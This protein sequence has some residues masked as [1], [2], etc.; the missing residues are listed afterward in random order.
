MRRSLPALIA[1]SVL[2]LGLTLLCT[3]TAAE[4]ATG[5]L[6]LSARPECQVWIDD[7]D[8]G[9]TDKTRNGIE[10][11]AGSYKVRFICE[12]ADCEGFERRSGVKTLTVEA[13][14][15]THYVADFYFLNDRTIG[16][17]QRAPTEPTEV[18]AQLEVP[19]DDEDL[20]PEPSEPLSP[21]DTTGVLRLSARP[22][23]AVE[24]DG[25]FAGTSDRTRLGVELEPG[26]Y[27]VRFICE[28]QVCEDFERRSGVK[29]LEVT[30]G[31]TVTYV[32]DF[33]AL[34]AR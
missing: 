20:G 34:N 32:A 4:Q 2:L 16:H 31:H 30:A 1:G 12:Q 27:H 19:R 22:R 23:V 21:T 13:G 28:E 26:T 33:Y 6:H 8:H 25:Q 5:S 29:T 10:L 17:Q 18:A 24:V 3:S 7:V 11:P 15:I 9:T 14:K